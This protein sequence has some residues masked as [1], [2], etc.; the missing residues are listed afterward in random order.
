MGHVRNPNEAKKLLRKLLQQRKD[1]LVEYQWS[2]KHVRLVTPSLIAAP[3]QNVWRTIKKRK[4]VVSEPVTEEKPII[5]PKQD[6]LSEEEKPIVSLN[7]DI[8]ISEEERPILSPDQD[9]VSYE[10]EK[11]IISPDQ[12]TVCYEE[13][14]PILLPDQE[15]VPYEE[16]KPILSP[17]WD[18]SHNN[19][20]S[21]SLPQ[22]SNED[23]DETVDGQKFSEKD[24]CEINN[25]NEDSG[26]DEDSTDD[27]QDDEMM[28][29]LKKKKEKQLQQHMAATKIQHWW[30]I[31]SAK[32]R[33]T[34]IEQEKLEQTKKV[35]ET[36]QQEIA[37]DRYLTQ[38]KYFNGN[39]CIVCGITGKSKLYHL[40]TDKS[41]FTIVEEYERFV[42]VEKELKKLDSS[43]EEYYSSEIKDKCN[44]DIDYSTVTLKLNGAEQ[45]K[46]WS[47]HED[48]GYLISEMQ[49]KITAGKLSFSSFFYYLLSLSVFS[50]R[51]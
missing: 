13:E 37:M 43:F 17:D 11:S 26:N 9:T 46:R 10:E 16:E 21:E 49:R 50:H 33:E 39:E 8:I 4:A 5:L 36:E 40:D 34:E 30:K 1:K 42:V 41:H 24:T 48:I 32:I 44:Y 6:L 23:F 19:I 45:R 47:D 3:E 51:I 2:V 35:T 29:E 27:E 28:L 12:E 22:V 7:Q 14:R 20:L 38:D 25:K 15:T 31:L 18:I